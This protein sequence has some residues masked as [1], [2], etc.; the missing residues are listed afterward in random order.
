MEEYQVKFGNQSAGKVQVSRQGLYY[1]LMCRCQ[2]SGDI[3]CRLQV[4][5]GEKKENLGVVVPMDGCFGLDTKIPVKRI[6]EGK[7]AFSLITK[8]EKQ[9]E[10]HFY[11]IFPEEP[12]AYI[13]R[14]KDAYLTRKEG[15]VGVVIKS[16]IT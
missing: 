2:L 12:F 3:L 11:P 4:S 5:C 1:R 9:T 6:G 16:N 8:Q 13:A 7:M 10:E 14:L 15:Q